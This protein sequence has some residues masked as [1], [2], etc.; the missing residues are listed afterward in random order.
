MRKLA[1][2]ILLILST[3]VFGQSQS[4]SEET[5]PEIKVLGRYYNNEIRLRWACTTP[6][7][8][9]NTNSYGF[10]VERYTTVR[11][12]M[13][14][15]NPEKKLLSVTP[16][17]AAPI[18]EWETIVENNNYG[19]IIA[20]ALYGEGF[21]VTGNEE[22]DALGSIVNQV[23][24]IEQRF[25]FSLFAA[26]MSY[27]AAVKAGWG[28]T[29]T[30]VLPN[31]EYFYKVKSAVPTDIIAI[32][33]GLILVKTNQSEELPQP[34]GLFAKG[35]NKR[36]RISWEY[37]SLKNIYTSYIIERSDNGQNFSR[38]G[39][40]PYI[41]LNDN[42]NNPN[43]NNSYTDTI[44]TNNKDFW[45]RIK[46][47]TPF[48]EESQPS[49]AIKAQGVDEQKDTP[50]IYDFVLDDFG[51]V[52][53]KWEFPAKAENNIKSF[54]L[55]LAPKATGP[56]QVVESAIDPERRSTQYDNLD[57]SN[58]FTISAIGKDNSVKTSLV[59]FVQTIDSIPPSIPIDITGTV[60]TLGVVKLKWKP[61]PESDML[62]Y[63]V[64]R[65]NSQ[66]EEFSQLTVSP[67]LNNTFV[68]TIQIK[69]LNKYIYYK[70]IAVDKRHNM[71][72]F[73]A[74]VALKKPDLVS[75]TSPVIKSYEVTNEGIRLAW[76]P[77]SSE[78]VVSHQVFR[79]NISANDST[80]VQ[81]YKTKDQ[82]SFIDKDVVSKNKYRY[83]VI[84]EDDSQL[85]S[86]PSSPV[87]LVMRGV[88][89]KQKNIK[90][91]SGISDRNNQLVV[92]SWK[93]MSDEVTEIVLYKNKKGEQPKLLR[94]FL[95]SIEGYKDKNVNPNSIY[96]YH[97]SVLLK[98]GTTQNQSIE[99]IY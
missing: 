97:L 5:L 4:T 44:P 94:Q 93:K 61:N 64:F 10:V 71:S 7:A 24:E 22:E 80:W 31:E 33:E 54:E 32:K 9:K 27:D 23:A 81:V 6:L 55:N 60:D 40:E 91:F 75:P 29:D 21:E 50:Y 85:Q 72:D 47:I 46:G 49:K 41:N 77:S 13:R 36:I 30:D 8:W 3:F 1:L 18:E 48:G 68:D 11:N 84:S 53:L 26:D 34:Y 90:L 15:E 45:Y 42:G 86:T 52:Q 66:N 56:F 43:L 39:D 2:S 16:I 57:P 28:I 58:Y 70:I 95:P 88:E 59:K 98:D 38:L 25:S 12:G 76:I 89:S 14:L 99:V 83:T 17:K 20:Q 96:E 78:D 82:T 19:A 37:Q 73:S 79:K 67:T 65:G 92:I 63:R 69:S 74:I 51:G 62:G 35:E 87:T